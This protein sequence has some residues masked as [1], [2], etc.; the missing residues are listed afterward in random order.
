MRF[1]VLLGFGVVIVLMVLAGAIG[2]H[3]ISTANDS[4]T[5]LVEVNNAKVELAN[6]MRESIRLRQISMHSMLAMDDPFKLDDELMHFYDY[7]GPYRVARRQLLDL[8]TDEREKDIHERLTQQV[9]IAQPL[10][11]RAAALL[12]ERRP[13][14]EIISAVELA[15]Q[16]QTKLLA[17]LDEL[18]E[19]QRDYAQQAVKTG[20]GELEETLL[21]VVTS[22]VIVV[23]L[24]LAIGILVAREVTRK[25]EELVQ[26]A[27]ATR[28]KSA[29]LA[30]MSHEIRTPLTAIIGFAETSLYSNQ[31]MEDRHRAISTIIRSGKHLLQIINDILDLS[32]IEANKLDIE[33]ASLSPFHL[34]AEIDPFVRPKA[35]EK[36][37]VYGVNY[38][39]PLPEQ[40]QSD[41]LRLKQILL[42]ICSNAVKFTDK[43]HVH[44][45]LSVDNQ[46]DQMTFEVVDSGIGMNEKQIEKVFEPFKQAD[47]STTGKYGGT[48]LGL[49]L[50]KQLA[51]ALGGSLIAE[52]EPG[53]G[54]HFKLTVATGPL[55]DVEMVY[56]KEHIPAP[57]QATIEPLPSEILSGTVLLAEDNQDNQQ[58]LSML[59]HR[60]GAD[61]TLADNGR[62][63]VD[64]AE[65]GDFDLIMMDMQMPEMDGLQAT[66]LL[67]ERGYDKPIVAL[68]ANAMNEDKNRCL[69]AGCNDFLTKPIEK[70]Q[71]HEVV[72]YYLRFRDEADSQVEPI[73]SVLLED[74]PEIIELV[75]NYIKNLPEVLKH[76]EEALK[77]KNWERL[78]DL[79]H[80][81]KGTG[82]NFGFVELSNLAGTIEFQ[83]MNMNMDELGG[84]FEKLSHVCERIIAG[85]ETSES[86]DASSAFLKGV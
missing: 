78:K 8:P 57:E 28:S 4:V 32:K 71:F 58:L 14:H 40:I 81:I 82:G 15:H 62:I 19:L 77:Q 16:E 50:S 9:R 85:V 64:K 36:G 61:V 70:E 75:H 31:S 33:R 5:T 3:Q 7:A 35:E 53:H 63:A 1:T 12:A 39:F 74:D 83:A 60:L 11:Q 26:A 10:N 86:E 66:R 47:S 21:L 56:D 13:R 20:Q 73:K 48:G 37:V 45:N 79:A 49:S 51:S 17:L 52:S 80:Q 38:Q 2:L 69:E 6:T 29:F 43:G 30:N 59:L 55:A 23:F 42:N 41:P 76:V 27:A 68:T 65:A 72:S 34:L 25:N 54:S 18:V 22:S 44:I 67:R 84:L 46:A 24:I